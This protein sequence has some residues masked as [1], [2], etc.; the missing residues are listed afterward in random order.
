MARRV[1][2]NLGWRVAWK[3]LSAVLNIEDVCIDKADIRCKYSPDRLEF[4][5]FRLILPDRPVKAH[6]VVGHGG[7]YPL[8]HVCL[9]AVG[10]YRQ[11]TRE[12]GRNLYDRVL[13]G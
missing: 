12:I 10:E 7:V 6:L 4:L 11:P 3:A 5:A 8:D 9:I 2:E 1:G 13:Q